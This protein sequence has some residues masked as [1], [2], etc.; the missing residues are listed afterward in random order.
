MQM[1]ETFRDERDWKKYHRSR[2]LAL[3]AMGELGEVAEILQFAPEDATEITTAQWEEILK[4]M[5]DVTI[6][7]MSMTLTLGEGSED[8]A[9]RVVER[10]VELQSADT[11]N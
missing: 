5:A 9:Q 10:V 1:V 11:V 7:C 4:E 2:S 3:A 6:Y 8:F